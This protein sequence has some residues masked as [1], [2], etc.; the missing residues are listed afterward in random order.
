MDELGLPYTKPEGGY[1]LLVNFAK[2]QIPE[3][4]KFPDEVTVGRT[5]DYQLAYG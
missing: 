2:V 5:G 1:F 4:Y 3:D